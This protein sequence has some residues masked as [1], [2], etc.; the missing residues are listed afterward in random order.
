MLNAYG[1]VFSRQLLVPLHYISSVF[2]DREGNKRLLPHFLMHLMPLDHNFQNPPPIRS[3]GW[4]PE[5][6]PRPDDQ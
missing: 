3:K 1:I 4:C 5:N 2:L 6:V